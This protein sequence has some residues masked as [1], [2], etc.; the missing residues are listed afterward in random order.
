[1]EDFDDEV[2]ATRRIQREADE[3]LGGFGQHLASYT[4]NRKHSAHFGSS[5]C[6][7][8]LLWCMLDVSNEGPS[9]ATITHL[10]W[11]L[12]FLKMYGTVDTLANKC[13]VDKNTY[14]KWTWLLLERLAELDDIVRTNYM[15]L[16]LLLLYYY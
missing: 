1:M 13:R 6:M 9:G 15:L 11:T 12:M 16:L 5:I 14:R 7:T 10:L 8:H 3:L 4:I 2:T